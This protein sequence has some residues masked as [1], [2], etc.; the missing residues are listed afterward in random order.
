MYQCNGAR[1]SVLPGLSGIRHNPEDPVFD[2]VSPEVSIR[3]IFGDTL[4]EQTRF[5]TVETM[6]MIATR[7]DQHD[8]EGYAVHRFAVL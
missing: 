4:R 1:F 8:N 3:C 7:R 5:A 6:M 2:P